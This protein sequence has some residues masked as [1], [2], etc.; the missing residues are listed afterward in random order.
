MFPICFDAIYLK[1]LVEYYK[2]FDLIKGFLRLCSYYERT[3]KVLTVFQI[4]IYS[5]KF[6]LHIFFFI[7]E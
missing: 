4:F 3:K 6:R 1:E 7:L 2:E 5:G